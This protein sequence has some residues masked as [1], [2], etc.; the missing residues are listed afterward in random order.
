M[1]YSADLGWSFSGLCSWKYTTGGMSRVTSE[2]KRSRIWVMGTLRVDAG[3]VVAVG[4]E[5]AHERQPVFPRALARVEQHDGH[6]AGL[7]VEVASRAELRK[8]G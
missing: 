1:M 8:N 7:A 3:A 2:A 4:V 6:V 5:H